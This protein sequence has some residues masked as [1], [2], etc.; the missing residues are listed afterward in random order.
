MEIRKIIMEIKKIVR[1]RGF[2][3]ALCMIIFE[4][5]HFNLEE[6]GEVDIESRLSEKEVALLLG[7]LIQDEID[8]SKPETPQ[9]LILLKKEIYE[10]MKKLHES[11][12][13]VY[14]KKLQKNLEKEKK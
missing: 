8:F 7:F 3:Y 13:V 14:P 4:D 9:E 5:F 10:V 12:I 1:T 11:F 2:I 6:I